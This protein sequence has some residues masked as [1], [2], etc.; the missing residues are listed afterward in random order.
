ML[1][2]IF[3]ETYVDFECNFHI[4]PVLSYLGRIAYP[5]L[6]TTYVIISGFCPG[7]LYTTKPNGADTHYALLRSGSGSV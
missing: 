3:R 6:S 2:Y 5:P 7:N 1:A 4:V